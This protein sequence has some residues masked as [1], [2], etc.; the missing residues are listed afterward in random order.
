VRADF[1]E[2]ARFLQGGMDPTEAAMRVS[3][4]LYWDD[5]KAPIAGVRLPASGA[6]TW[7]AYKGSQVLS[8]AGNATNTIYFTAQLPHQYHEGSDIDFHI[9]YVPEDNTAGNHR[10]VF[11]HSWASVNTAFPTETTVTTLLAT[12]EVTDQHTIGA[13]TAA[14]T[15]TGKNVSS[16]LLCSLARTGGHADDTY[17]AKAIYLISFDF[18]VQKDAEGSLKRTSK[19]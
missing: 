17:N 19:T 11:T 13:I 4:H 18:H 15:G 8:F 7:T 2:F 5:E 9:H 10:W 1:R 16:V 12:P 6:P 14:I 3:R